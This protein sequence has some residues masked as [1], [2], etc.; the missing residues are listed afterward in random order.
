MRASVGLEASSGIIQR[1]PARCV[2][3]MRFSLQRIPTRRWDIP[4]FFAASKVD[5]YFI[6]AVSFHNHS[7]DI[8]FHLWNHINVYPVNIAAPEIASLQFLWAAFFTPD[9]RVTNDLPLR[10]EICEKLKFC[11][12]NNI[13]RKNLRFTKWL[14]CAVYG[15]EIH[16]QPLWTE[17]IFKSRRKQKLSL[18]K[19]K[20]NWKKS[21]GPRWGS[22]RPRKAFWTVT[23]FWIRR[24][25]MRSGSWFWK[26]HHASRSNKGWTESKTLSWF[27]SITTDAMGW[28]DYIFLPDRF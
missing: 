17:K 20:L 9:G 2:P 28:K 14:R 25:K 19:S 16:V 4:P 15:Y 11:A 3:G 27:T 8:I 12:V 18:W 1:L 26:K 5:M 21:T 6:S 22:F 13:P 7:K 24:R 23:T 10:G